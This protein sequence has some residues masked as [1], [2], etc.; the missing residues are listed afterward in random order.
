MQTLPPV[1]AATGTC[2]CATREAVW[3]DAVYTTAAAAGAPDGSDLTELWLRSVGRAATA[4]LVDRILRVRFP[5]LRA[6]WAA[7]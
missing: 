3:P 4:T 7:R 6:P 5:P 1:V 2:L